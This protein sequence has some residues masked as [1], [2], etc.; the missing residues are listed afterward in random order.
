MISAVIRLRWDKFHRKVLYWWNK[1]RNDQFVKANRL[2]ERSLRI[3]QK[4]Y[5]YTIEQATYQLRK[6]YSKA[7]LE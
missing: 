7:R 4:R 1:P 2:H 3:L 5:G 6:Y